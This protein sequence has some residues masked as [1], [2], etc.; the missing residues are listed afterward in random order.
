MSP[1]IGTASLTIS[2]ASDAA[3]PDLDGEIIVGITRAVGYG[4]VVV[5]IDGDEYVWRC[6]CGTGDDSPF[7]DATDAYH[8]LES[9]HALHRRFDRT[10]AES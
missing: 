10:E 1:E 9:H 5:R 7:Q 4:G 2:E 6:G 8:A 3:W